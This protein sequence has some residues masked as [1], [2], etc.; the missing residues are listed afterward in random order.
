MAVW[1]MDQIILDVTGASG[2]RVGDEV[3]AL[4]SQKSEEIQTRELALRAHTIPWGNPHQ[5]R[6]PRPPLL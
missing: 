5:H 6:R 1:T 2:C 4:G 3:V